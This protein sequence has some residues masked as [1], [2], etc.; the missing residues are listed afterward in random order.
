MKAYKVTDKLSGISWYYSS[1]TACLK[2]VEN[3]LD[4]TNRRWSQIVKEKGYPFEHSG[5][6]VEL[7]QIMSINDVEEDNPPVWEDLQKPKSKQ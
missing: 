2:H 5:C 4:V 3:P 7:I 6:K 1:I